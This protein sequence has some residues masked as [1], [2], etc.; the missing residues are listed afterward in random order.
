MKHTVYGIDIAKTVFQLHTVDMTT[1]EIVSLKLKREKFLAHFV[2]RQPCVIGMEA[3]GGAQHWARELIRLGHTVKLLSG[4]FVKSFVMGNK[5]DAADARAIWMAVQ[6]P[7]VKPIA[8]KTELQQAILALHRLRQGLVKTRTM[9]INALRGLL[10]EY[11]VVMPK[12]KAG[13][14]QGIAAALEAIAD[15]L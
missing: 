1:G 9:Q 8:I 14:R 13:I 4:R 6:Q 11:G 10:T 2:N 5:S 3:C 12:G 7:G 15:R